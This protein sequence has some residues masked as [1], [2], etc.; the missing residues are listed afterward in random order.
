MIRVFVGEG[1]IF[2]GYIVSLR[3][4]RCRGLAL[5]ISSQDHINAPHG[6]LRL[7]FVAGHIHDLIEHD[8]TSRR[9]DHIEQKTLHKAD[10]V[11][12]NEPDNKRRGH[13]HQETGIDD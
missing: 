6:L 11:V 13:Q 9:E 7:H 12:G 3:L 5:R 10:Q 1:H 8:C 4:F 2:K